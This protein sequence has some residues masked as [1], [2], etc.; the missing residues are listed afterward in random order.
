MR[1][2]LIRKVSPFVVASSLLVACGPS[3][4]VETIDK[5]DVKEQH[6]S[7]VAVKGLG[8]DTSFIDNNVR[9]QDD[10]YRY[11][12]GRWIESAVIP[13]DRTQVSMFSG[14]S[15][16]NH[17]KQRE[18]L[19][20]LSDLPSHQ[21]SAADRQLLTLYESFI[22]P[23]H[24]EQ[25]SESYLN[26][27]FAKIDQVE[28]SADVADLFIQLMSH[29]IS[30]PISVWVEPDS[31]NPNHY[32]LEVSQGGLGMRD[33]RFYLRDDDETEG[34]RNAYLNM[35]EQG[36]TLSGL[37]SPK[38]LAEQVL[39]VESKIAASQWSREDSQD[40]TKSYNLYSRSRIDSLSPSIQWNALFDLL[41]GSHQ[42]YVRVYQ[43]SYFSKLSKL[44]EKL[45]IEYW[46]SY[47]KWQVMVQSLSNMSEPYQAL[48]QSFFGELIGGRSEAQP[49][50]RTAIGYINK[51]MGDAMAARY[52]D[53]YFSESSR[54]RVQVMV[55]QILDTTEKDL[56][57]KGWFADDTRLLAKQKIVDMG[58]KVGYPDRF[59]NFEGLALEQGQLLQNL[60][61]VK[62][63]QFKRKLKKLDRRVSPDDWYRSPQ[64]VA[65][66]YN[67]ASNEIVFPAGILVPPFFDPEADDAANYGGI[68][69]LIGHEIAHSLDKIGAQLDGSGL[70][71]RWWSDTDYER[72]DKQLRSL[73]HQ[74]S[75]YEILPGL[76]LSSQLSADEMM[77]DLI[78]VELA[79]SAYK[80]SIKEQPRLDIEGFN[81]SERFFI[82]YAQ[83]WRVKY[84]ESYMRRAMPYLTYAPGEARVNITLRNVE[85][86]N[87]T[88]KVS[89]KDGMYV[90]PKRRAKIW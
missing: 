14:L 25:Q 28:S 84:R 51:Y 43:P 11:A 49:Q 52:I 56:D 33:R 7:E 46:Q 9:A 50:W 76:K 2:Q 77:A 15:D 69:A 26:S 65:A 29:G 72:F 71:D 60:A 18:L 34:L 90:E 36:F 66:Y 30:G 59:D 81:A 54:T 55:Q 22:S 82:S 24:L 68:G 41:D 6:T 17:H 83:A 45:P 70:E 35:I 42:R 48:S 78:G 62:T 12:N 40:R 75:K 21:M 63:Y 89:E 44:L 16:Q 20:G 3:P 79:Y 32:I 19:E 86:F 31:R 87:R 74:F 61:T 1:W 88:Y 47:L 85:A 10:F 64:S 57:R 73:N 23:A 39:V 13:A 27:Y 58:V 67:P 5:P 53:R 38:R 37:S 8:F 4:T 80:K